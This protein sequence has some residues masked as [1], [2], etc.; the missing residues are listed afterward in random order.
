MH[1][2]TSKEGRPSVRA[3]SL[4]LRTY[5]YVVFLFLD[6]LDYAQLSRLGY[7]VMFQKIFGLVLC[8]VFSFSSFCAQRVPQR[9]DFQNYA[10]GA[11]FYV[12]VYGSG[13][14]VRLSIAE[15]GASIFD[16]RITAAPF[17]GISNGEVSLERDQDTLVCQIYKRAKGVLFSFSINLNGDLELS[18]GGSS[19]TGIEHHVKF[20]IKTNGSA[21]NNHP[22]A[23]DSLALSCRNF[24]NRSVLKSNSYTLF[25]DYFYN[26]G[27]IDSKS[28]RGPIP[29]ED[30]E[31]YVPSLS[32]APAPTHRAHTFD[33]FGALFGNDLKAFGGL[34]VN[35]TGS[36]NVENLFVERGSVSANCYFDVS[37]T[38]TGNVTSLDV[39]DRTVAN[40]GQIQ[41]SPM[42][43][44][45]VKGNLRVG[46][47]SSLDA[48][49]FENTGRIMAEQSLRILT[50][51]LRNGEGSILAKDALE[52]VERSKEGIKQQIQEGETSQVELGNLLGKTV[53]IV[54]HTDHYLNTI[55][56]YRFPDGTVSHRTETGYLFQRRET[57]TD[58]QNLPPAVQMAIA[59]EMAVTNLLL[60]A[61]RESLGVLDRIGRELKAQME[62]A[63]RA[64]GSADDVAVDMRELAALLSQNDEDDLEKF[65]VTPRVYD[66]LSA[67]NA[68][69][70]SLLS[71][72]R[73]RVDIERK[74]T[75][76][77]APAAAPTGMR[78]SPSW[79][80]LT[81]VAA[82]QNKAGG[83]SFESIASHLTLWRYKMEKLAANNPRAYD[84]LMAAWD[85]KV[86]TTL[87]TGAISAAAAALETGG[88]SLLAYGASLGTGL[89]IDWVASLVARYGADVAAANAAEGNPRL[90]AS[91]KKTF[92]FVGEQ[93]TRHG[94]RAGIRRSARTRAET[95]RPAATAQDS[96]S[97]APYDP[98]VA[99]R[100]AQRFGPVE[101]ST[102]PTSSQPNVRLAGSHIQRV[103]GHDPLTHEPI[104]QRVVFDQRGFPIFDPY[105]KYQTRISGN[106]SSMSPETHMRMATRQLRADIE[107]GRVN[108]SLFSDA[109][110]ADIRDGTEKIGK[111]TWH[112]HQE[113]GRMQLVPEDIHEW[114]RHVGGNK[115][116]GNR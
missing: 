91:F 65:L 105:I 10:R 107:A 22:I 60:N 62:A 40:F 103:A 81:H 96:V 1:S 38:L 93:V 101:R 45:S 74:F 8:L 42:E 115:L 92:D 24:Y 7:L 86:K 30:Y 37:N 71:S 77:T 85:L 82:V 26:G 46:K 98:R 3:A 52:V 84:A 19:D 18:T 27:V 34:S 53:K 75:V 89:G 29:W 95:Q 88:A 41:T 58:T 36:F 50:E 72:I 80:D 110:F 94:V 5:I 55:T 106:L 67:H 54:H 111:F 21:H 43:R 28:D 49:L 6:V 2:G 39:G 48:K 13:R 44:L 69:S 66:A 104:V 61:L 100:I 4:V 113:T 97:K 109:E 33:K 116:W 32:S 59:V 90:Y 112:H 76:R 47:S 68:A 16:Q 12:D 78:R 102:V 51:K 35:S 23:F 11:N 25:A 14:D 31:R 79:G 17:T 15:N 9:E 87:A 83:L 70:R 20:A 56:T 57:K 64:R 99:E 73:S 114:A 63:V 108:R